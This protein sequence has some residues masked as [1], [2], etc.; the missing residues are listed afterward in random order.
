MLCIFSRLPFQSLQK[1]LYLG[2]L[3]VLLLVEHKSGTGERGAVPEGQGFLHQVVPAL[4][5]DLRQHGPTDA[6]GDYG[7]TGSD[8][9]HL[10][11]G[12]GIRDVLLQLPALDPGHER[13][14]RLPVDIGQLGKGIFHSLYW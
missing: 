12:R 3:S 5:A 10:D 2:Q 4:Q 13:L 9:V 8:V 7:Q 14:V 1:N 6:A 11:G